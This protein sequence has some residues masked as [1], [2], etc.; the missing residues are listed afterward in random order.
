[1]RLLLV[2]VS[3]YGIKNAVDELSGLVGRKA[4]S[5]FEGFIN[6]DRAWSWFVKKLVN[7][8]AEDVAINDCH[9]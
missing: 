6:R 7:G 2:E 8:E 3:L 5:D 4:T 1:M 9:A